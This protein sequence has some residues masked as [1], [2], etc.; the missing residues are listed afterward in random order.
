MVGSGG[1]SGALTQYFGLRSEKIAQKKWKT[2]M[3]A[4]IHKLEDDSPTALLRRL[5]E[6]EDIREADKREV[7]RVVSALRTAMRTALDQLATIQD[8][9]KI[10][11]I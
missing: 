11:T 9:L 4:R 5:E 6:V 2:D 8:R 10:P 3:E 1:L 7:F